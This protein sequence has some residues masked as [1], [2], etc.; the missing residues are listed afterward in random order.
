ME[1]LVTLALL[2]AIAGY[3]L[4]STFAGRGAIEISAVLLVGYVAFAFLQS[5]LPHAASGT[6]PKELTGVGMGFYNL[7]FFMSGAFSASIVGR[8]LDVHSGKACL[9]PFASCVP[10]WQYSNIYL[11]LSAVSA[12]ALILYRRG[13]RDAR[14]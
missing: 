7:V 6:L 4:L 5:S 12:L 14:S 1:T 9:N 10:G 3:L 13:L 11:K 8:I 2:L